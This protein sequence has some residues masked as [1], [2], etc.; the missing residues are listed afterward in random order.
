MNFNQRIK[1]VKSI[2]KKLINTPKSIFLV[3][4]DESEYE[5]YINKKYNISLFP[6]TDINNFLLQ[7]KSEINHITFLDGTSTVTDLALLK[8]LASRF[9]K[10]NYLEIGTWRGESILNVADVKNTTCT[11][12]SLSPAE[13]IEIGLSEKYAKLQNCLI[14]D[15]KNIALIQANS[16]TY[17]F[18]KLNQKFD[19]IFVDGDHSYE[20][21]KSDTKN[22]FQLLKNDDSIIVWHDYGYNPETPR[23]SVIAAIL[24]GLEKSEHK[25]LYHVSN[26][27]CAIYTKRKIDSVLLDFPIKPDKIFKVEIE[28]TVI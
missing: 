27:M 15:V 1:A 14:K 19:L 22:I 21:V 20:A 6:T 7:G 18:S 3:L 16:L 17:D 10:C 5:K 23:Y 4:K 8:S 11:S 28:S 2:V 24:D 12:I 9:D 13:I 26:T 25:Y